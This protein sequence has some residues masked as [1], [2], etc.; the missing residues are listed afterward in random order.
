MDKPIHD[1]AQLTAALKRYGLLFACLLFFDLACTG[2]GRYL[3]LGWFSPR[4]LLV[5]LTLGCSLPLF[6]LDPVKR[7][8]GLSH[9][10]RRGTVGG[11]GPA[12]VKAMEEAYGSRP[13]DILCVIGPSICGSCYEVGD[14]IYEEMTETWGTAR[15]DEVMAQIGGRW[16]LDLHRAAEMTLLKA[17]LKP[18]HIAVTDVCTR[19]SCDSLYSLRGDG[20]IV[21]QIAS[22]LRL[23]P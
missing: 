3:A 6:F 22:A 11:I 19:C 18:E 4:I 8:A 21:N 16:H 23:L 14:E 15:T 10:G 20:R 5:L 2:S 1:K 9:S 13:E 17:G 7:A 12:T